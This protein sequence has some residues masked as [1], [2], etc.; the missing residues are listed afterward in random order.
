MYSSRFFACKYKGLCMNPQ[1]RTDRIFLPNRDFG[2]FNAPHFHLSTTIVHGQLIS[3]RFYQQ[4]GNVDLF[5]LWR[6]A[7]FDSCLKSVR[8]DVVIPLVE[9]SFEFCRFSFSMILV[10]CVHGL[11]ILEMKSWQ[12][13]S[14]PFF[15]LFDTPS[16]P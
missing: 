12:V 10:T 16:N 6:F 11:I 15:G 3:F 9:I 2:N 5:L 8:A 1:K 7:T 14:L 13:S 4:P